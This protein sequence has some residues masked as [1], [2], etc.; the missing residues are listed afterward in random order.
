MGKL[1][2]LASNDNSGQPTDRRFGF[3]ADIQCPP[4]YVKRTLRKIDAGSRK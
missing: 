3:E 1:Q 2:V 4:M